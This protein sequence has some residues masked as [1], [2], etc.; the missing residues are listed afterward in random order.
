MCTCNNNKTVSVK[1]GMC[2]LKSFLTATARKSFTFVSQMSEK[3][4]IIFWYCDF[5][6]KWEKLLLR[7]IKNL[8]CSWNQNTLTCTLS[9]FALHYSSNFLLYLRLCRAQQIACMVTIVHATC[10]QRG[11][12]LHKIMCNLNQLKIF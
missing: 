7:E 12:C 11:F 4:L 10:M 6:C 1:N 2:I 9:T 3:K 5:L 8:S